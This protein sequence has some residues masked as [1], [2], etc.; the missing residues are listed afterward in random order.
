MG[1]TRNKQNDTRYGH[2]PKPVMEVSGCPPCLK[3]TIRNGRVTAGCPTNEPAP[4]QIPHDV[5]LVF[6]KGMSEN[7]NFSVGGVES[8]DKPPNEVKQP[9]D[10]TTGAAR[11]PATVRPTPCGR[12][13]TTTARECER[14]GRPGFDPGSNRA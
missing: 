3:F 13:S 9:C 5:A 11:W 1:V 6:N 7:L 14:E 12:H 8:V 10:R 2:I 4:Y